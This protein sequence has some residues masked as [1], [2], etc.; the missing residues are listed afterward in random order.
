MTYSVQESDLF[1]IYAKQT[2]KL[3]KYKLRIYQN[4]IKAEK[5]EL[6]RTSEYFACVFVAKLC[7]NWAKK[8]FVSACIFS[9]ITN[10]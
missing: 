5:I 7:G 6:S 1:S 8:M 3:V 9:D 2:F 4:G 10:L